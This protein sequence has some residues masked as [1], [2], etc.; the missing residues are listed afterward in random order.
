MRR[1]LG[2]Y[3]VSG[4]RTTVPFFTWLLAQPDFEA[5]R[6]HT[7]YLDEILKARNGRPFVEPRPEAEDVAAIAAALQAALVDRRPRPWCGVAPGAGVC[8]R[9]LESAARA[10]KGCADVQYEVEVN[11]RIRQVTVQRREGGFVVTVGDREWVVDAA[12]VERTRL[13]LLVD[14]SPVVLEPRK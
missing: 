6:F 7:T 4:I 8:R 1:A 2:E 14:Q 5:G 10:A 12:R 13:S 3:V 11:G 9:R